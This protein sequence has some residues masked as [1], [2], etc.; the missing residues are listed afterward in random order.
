M[1]DETRRKLTGEQEQYPPMF[2]AIKV[3]GQPLYKKARAGKVVEVTP[4]PVNIY[5]FELTKIEMPRVDFFVRCSKGTY[6]RSLAYD[7][8]KLL[9]SGGLL[10]RLE[11]LA[12]GEFKLQ[13]AWHLEDLVRQI[14]WNSN[15]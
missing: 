12:I 3:D 7:F 6:V 4:R 9:S 11:R 8:G 1:L 2:S 10:T 15:L 13:N 5:E 14:N